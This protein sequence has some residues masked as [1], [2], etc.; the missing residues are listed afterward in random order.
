[1]SSELSISQVNTKQLKVRQL[2]LADYQSVWQA[3]QDFTKTR[4]EDTPD[5]IW[6]VEHPP[7]FTL[8]R[9]GKPEHIL[10]DSEIPVIKVD[11]GGQVTYHG[12]GQIVIYLLL[13]LHRRKL[14]IRKLG[15]LIEDCIVELLGQFNLTANSDPKAPGVYVDGK[16]VAALGYEYQ[17]VELP[18]V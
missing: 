13:D 9:N 18:M 4:D 16:K 3:M 7:I 15:T 12:P 17:K 14:G 5:E 1:M 10:H 6:V 8:G 11:R 2:G